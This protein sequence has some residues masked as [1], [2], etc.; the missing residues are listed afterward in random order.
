[1]KEFL[2][3]LKNAFQF[4]FLKIKDFFIRLLPN[5]KHAL[6]NAKE[7][8]EYVK[9][10]AMPYLKAIKLSWVMAW[11]GCA[12]LIATTVIVI[13]SLTTDYYMLTYKEYNLGFLRNTEMAD[14]TMQSLKDEFSDNDAV[15]A[16]LDTFGIE[17]IKIGNIFLKCM[18]KDEFR[19]TVVLA[20]E[21]IEYGYKIYI[22]DEF[23]MSVAGKDVYDNALLDYKNDRITISNDI[24][25]EYDSCKVTVTNK[26]T[27]E[28]ECMLTKDIVTHGSYQGL[29]R[30]F[31]KKL[32]Y[33]IEC[34]QTETK[35]VPYITYYQRNAE[36]YPGAKN[37]IS[38]G[39]YGAKKV[40]YK[41]IVEDGKLISS[42]IV[43]EKV[44]KKAVMRKV[45][46]G[47]GTT[48]GMAGGIVLGLPVEGY[49]TSDFGNRS[50]PFTG[51]PAYHNGLDIGA[52]YGTPIIAAAEGKV[53]QASDKKNGYGKCVIIE[54]ASGFRTMYAHASSLNVKV[55]QYVKAGQVIAKVGSTG[56]STGP[57]LHFSV[58]INGDYVDPNLYF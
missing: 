11:L 31:E 14:A 25:S 50:D 15:I 32:H 5:V 49:L 36:L 3:V 19:E 57:H 29:Y 43:S 6:K 4:G 56:R 41:V 7:K 28:R 40:Q 58:I 30:A 21:T 27:Y 51:K 26:L 37:I 45:E 16:D 9:D 2:V 23:I 1:M 10:W 8:R 52:K 13:L 20:A 18:D 53:I 17:K 42:T 12:L 24:N 48:S 34:L 46:I 38:Q 54:H 44:T 39:R 33:N 47:N 35:Q 22:D 55:G